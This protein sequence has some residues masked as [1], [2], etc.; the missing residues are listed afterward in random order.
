MRSIGESSFRSNRALTELHLGASLASIGNYAGRDDNLA[1]ITV[2]P[3]APSIPSTAGSCTKLRGG[4][5]LGPFSPTNTVSELIVPLIAVE[6]A[7][8]ALGET[9]PASAAVVLL[10]GHPS[11][12]EPSTVSKSTELSSPRFRRG[13]QGVVNTG[14]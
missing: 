8:W 6:I 2:S 11:A 14:F 13:I 4:R 9:T 3:T 10:M 7:S 12:T 5:Q 1:T